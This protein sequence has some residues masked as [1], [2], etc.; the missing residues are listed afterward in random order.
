MPEIDAVVI[1]PPMLKTTRY[2]SLK[3][4]RK[5]EKTLLRSLLVEIE[6]GIWESGKIGA[7]VEIAEQIQITVIDQVSTLLTYITVID[8]LSTLLTYITVIDQVSTLFILQ[9]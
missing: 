4:E 3:T 5:Q 2:A 8:Q 7:A 1:Q 6:C 9:L